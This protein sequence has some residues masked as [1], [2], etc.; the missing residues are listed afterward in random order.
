MAR[1]MP[2]KKFDG[3]WYKYWRSEANRNTAER[4]AEKKR[5]DGWLVRVVTIHAFQFDLYIRR[6]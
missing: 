4:K 1:V 6:A 3:K 5:K 2:S